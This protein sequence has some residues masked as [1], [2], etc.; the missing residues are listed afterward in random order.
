M[1]SCEQLA[2]SGCVA[3]SATLMQQKGLSRHCT[4]L[5]DFQ[6]HDLYRVFSL[7][8]VQTWLLCY[9]NAMSQC[10]CNEVHLGNGSVGLSRPGV[11][12]MWAWP[13]ALLG[14]LRAMTKTTLDSQGSDDSG[15]F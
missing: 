2:L 6:K 14:L 8:T 7:S 11:S 3:P 15:Q 10:E 13:G 4:M 5:L 1:S 12:R 9:S